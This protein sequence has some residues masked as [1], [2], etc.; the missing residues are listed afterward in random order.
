MRRGLLLHHLVDIS[1]LT[2][3]RGEYIEQPVGIDNEG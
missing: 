1:H 3:V 2:L